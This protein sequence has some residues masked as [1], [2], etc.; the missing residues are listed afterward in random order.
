MCWKR[1]NVQSQLFVYTINLKQI[2]TKS[3]SSNLRLLVHLVTLFHKF[4]CISANEGLTGM[5]K[6]LEACGMYLG[7][8]YPG[9]LPDIE[10]EIK[11]THSEQKANRT[12][13]E[14]M[15]CELRAG[16]S[17][18]YISVLVIRKNVCFVVLKYGLVSSEFISQNSSR[19]AGENYDY[20]QFYSS[21]RKQRITVMWRGKK[22]SITKCTKVFYSTKKRHEDCIS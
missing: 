1:L 2:F 6:K 7:I 18:Y 20:F 5:D 13:S 12:Q 19:S 10:R 16:G 17:Y 8:Y 11:R 15:H 4:L 14:I 21:D 22:H 3:I 9:V